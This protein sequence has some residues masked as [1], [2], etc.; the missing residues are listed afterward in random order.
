MLLQSVISSRPA[1]PVV[2]N[3]ETVICVYLP[4]LSQE[5][6]SAL[7]NKPYAVWITQSALIAEPIAS[8]SDFERTQSALWTAVGPHFPGGQGM[9][10]QE[11]AWILVVALLVSG[12]C[13]AGPDCQQT[14]GPSKL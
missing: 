1:S 3:R 13:C 7:A 5:T 11:T 6:V 4:T 9:K 8:C 14:G 2:N 10:K 12:P